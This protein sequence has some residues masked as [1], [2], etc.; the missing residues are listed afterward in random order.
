MQANQRSGQP[1]LLK[2]RPEN[3]NLVVHNDTGT[4]FLL[5]CIETHAAV[6]NDKQN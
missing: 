3:A 2:C 6:D 4:G 5:S 1:T